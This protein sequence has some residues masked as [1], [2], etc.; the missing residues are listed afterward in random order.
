MQ[1]IETVI[2]KK[3]QVH[4]LVQRKDR[5]TFNQDGNQLIINFEDLKKKVDEKMHQFNIVER[6]QNQSKRPGHHHSRLSI[7]G[8]Q[9]ITMA[10]RPSF[11]R[12]DQ[13]ATQD[14]IEKSISHEIQLPALSVTADRISI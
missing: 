1:K 2:H 14:E 5:P 12:L 9:S 7:G 13:S 4:G 3:L 6:S 8:N 11:S 10:S